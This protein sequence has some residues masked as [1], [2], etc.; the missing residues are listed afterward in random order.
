MASDCS[1]GVRAIRRRLPPAYR[2]PI[3][4]KSWTGDGLDV[5][6]YLPEMVLSMRIYG[7]VIIATQRTNRRA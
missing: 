7:V 1:R 4:P 6:L 3:R 2:H 5:L